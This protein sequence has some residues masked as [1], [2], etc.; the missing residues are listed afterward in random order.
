[1]HVTFRGKR[2]EAANIYTFEWERPEDFNYQA[3]QYIK[4]LLPHQNADERGEMHWF[5][6]S[7]SPSESYLSNTTKFSQPSSTFKQTL[8]A[9]EPGAKAEMTGPFGE[10]VLPEDAA[11]KLV[12]VAGGIGVTPYRSILKW[13]NDKDQ[14]RPI[15]L[16]YAANQP[17][18]LAFRSLF[19]HLPKPMEV[20][21]L[22]SKPNA[23]WS[24]QVG[25]LSG[26]KIQELSNGLENKLT[27]LSGPKPMVQAFKDQLLELG[28]NEAKIITDFFP[29][30][31]KI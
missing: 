24:G 25:Q 5:T 20:T 2:P 10:F 7:S 12:F 21:Y 9:L 23:G 31:E 30:Y 11:Q 28:I 14:T 13:L 17:R 26:E 16:L 22:V 15:Q 6:L 19:D 4:L 1:M 29:G 8:I 27:Y 3:G 18:E